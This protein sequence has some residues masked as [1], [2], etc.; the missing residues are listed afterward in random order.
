MVIY[1]KCCRFEE[2]LYL[3][4]IEIFIGFVREWWDM[5]EWVEFCEKLLLLLK[6]NVSIDYGYF[7]EIFVLINLNLIYIIENLYKFIN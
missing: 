6:I 5:W 3:C 4:I 1:R 2:G 7:L